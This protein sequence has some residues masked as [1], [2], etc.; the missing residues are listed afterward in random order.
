MKV[1]TFDP[2]NLK[3][4]RADLAAALASV[5]EKYDVAFSIGNIS[6]TGTSFNAKLTASTMT[7][8]DDDF[9]KT[10]AK[11]KADYERQAMRFGLSKSD[12]GR[13]VTINHETFTIVGA[14]PRS[15]HVILQSGQGK[16]YKYDPRPVREFLNR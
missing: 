6:Y 1:E 7:P 16:N 3:A 10:N 11:W 2:T 4:I 5:S 9:T 14:T 12:L 15:G 13:C 8:G